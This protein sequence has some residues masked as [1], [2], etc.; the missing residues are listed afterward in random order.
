MGASVE[1]RYF[2]YR[3]KSSRVIFLALAIIHGDAM[4]R[5]GAASATNAVVCN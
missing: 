5:E 3:A 4:V 2:A 1:T